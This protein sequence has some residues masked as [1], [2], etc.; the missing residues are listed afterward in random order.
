MSPS[1]MG[2]IT[3]FLQFFLEILRTKTRC[4]YSTLNILVLNSNFYAQLKPCF[5][6]KKQIVQQTPPPPLHK[7]KKHTQKKKNKIII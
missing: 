5:L 4:V 6:R 7:K 1:Q 3:T 2:Q